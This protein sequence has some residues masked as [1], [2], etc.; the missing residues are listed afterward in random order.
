[1]PE[2][3]SL[4]SATPQVATAAL[5]GVSQNDLALADAPPASSQ[6][7]TTD[8]KDG[9]RAAQSKDRSVKTASPADPPKPST[10][11][12][13]AE[14]PKGVPGLAPASDWKPKGES[15][16]QWDQLKQQHSAERT[17][18]ESE[19]AALKGRLGEFETA[20]VTQD[21]LKTLQT[22]RDQL[23]EL[24]RD[25]AIERDPE[26]NRSFKAREGAAID[27]AKLAAGDSAAKLEA[28]LKAP[29]GPWRDEQINALMD[30]LPQS[31]QRRVNAALAVRP[32]E[33]ARR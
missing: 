24:L 30:G 15:A 13:P 10:T 6:L 4:K 23:R 19:L 29:P 8:F 14:P 25:V 33:A 11:A 17:K 26:F 21:G 1:M 3:V 12:A 16:K 5:E 2:E 20:G 31:S 7:D 18:L 9:L 22:E 32:D 28:L 27:Q